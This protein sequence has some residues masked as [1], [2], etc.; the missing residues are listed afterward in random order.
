MKALARQRSHRVLIKSSDRFWQKPRWQEKK[1]HQQHF[2][3]HSVPPQLAAKSTNLW[4]LCLHEM[5]N[6]HHHE[7]MSVLSRSKQATSHGRCS[8]EEVTVG[9]LLTSS[10]AGRSFIQTKIHVAIK[11]STKQ[12]SFSPESSN[13][14]AIFTPTLRKYSCIHLVFT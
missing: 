4:E 11:T 5:L 9:V 13:T 10:D 8:G 1:R 14:R 12:K 7:K 2:E 6:H 3:N